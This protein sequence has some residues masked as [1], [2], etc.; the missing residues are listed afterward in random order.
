MN[1]A[2]VFMYGALSTLSL[3]AGLFFLRY[4]RLTRDP[5]FVW[6][7]TAFWTF[8]LNWTVLAHDAEASAP[9]PL[10]FVFRLAGFLQILTAI[11]LKNRRSARS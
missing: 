11:L 9:T 6:F 1:E 2:L 3:V 4:W 7:A 10:G 5:F 8:A